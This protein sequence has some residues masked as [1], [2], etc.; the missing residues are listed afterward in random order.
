MP[1]G[2][3]MERQ[4]ARWRKDEGGIGCYE[5][6]AHGLCL[7]EANGEKTLVTRKVSVR[8]GECEWT[9]RSYRGCGLVRDV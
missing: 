4:D 8:R 2:S 5:R 9:H 1:R 3:E 6:E 7:F